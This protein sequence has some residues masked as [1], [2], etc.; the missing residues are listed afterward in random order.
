MYG[1]HILFFQTSMNDRKRP[2]TVNEEAGPT[3]QDSVKVSFIS[4]L[5]LLLLPISLKFFKFS[6][7]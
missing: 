3:E 6:S 7:I 5:L 2:L 1:I 4:L